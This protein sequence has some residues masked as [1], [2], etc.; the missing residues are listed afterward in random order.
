MPTY[1]RLLWGCRHKC[2]SAIYVFLSLGG[3]TVKVYRMFL[4]AIIMGCVA[5]LAYAF[6]QDVEKL[7]I[8]HGP[9]LQAVTESSVTA[10][11][12]TNKSCVSRVEYTL[13]GAPFDGNDVKTALASHHGLI[14]ANTKIQRIPL[15]GLKPGRRYKYRVVSK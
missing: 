7:A 4:T 1:D 8:T 15:T 3:R 11:W 12:F 9:Y 5:D 14:D 13:E 6:A 10:V 2:E